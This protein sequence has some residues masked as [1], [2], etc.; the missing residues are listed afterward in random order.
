MVGACRSPVKTPADHHIPGGLGVS[1]PHAVQGAGAAASGGDTV[2]AWVGEIAL[3]EED[4]ARQAA[5]AHRVGVAPTTPAA[6]QTLLQNL[7]RFEL[8]AQEADRRGLMQDPE[9]LHVAR[10][11]A[12]AK[13]IQDEVGRASDPARI[14]DADVQRFHDEKLEHMFTRPAAVRVLDLAVRDER[15]AQRLWAIARQLAPSDEQGFVAL[16]LAHGADPHLTK[17]KGDR[18]FVDETSVLPKALVRAALSLSKPGEVSDPVPTEDGYVH[19]LRLQARRAPVVQGLREAEPAIRQQIERERR[20]R[21]IEA[22][23]ERLGTMN[24]VRFAA[25]RD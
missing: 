6:R 1:R 7:V 23:V 2:V 18:G 20:G 9:V 8:L 19:L 22:L 14:T 10:Q 3:T 13:L 21:A 15:E 11:Q 12:V 24:K 4:L 25:K 17:T 16:V 5:R